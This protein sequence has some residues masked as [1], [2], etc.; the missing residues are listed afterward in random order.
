MFKLCYVTHS[1][2]SHMPEMTAVAKPPGCL[3]SAAVPFLACPQ[4]V[5]WQIPQYALVGE[6][7]ACCICPCTCSSCM[8]FRS[9]LCLHCKCVRQ[10]HRA[11]RIQWLSSA[12]HAAGCSEVFSLVGAYEL[13]YS[14]ASRLSKIRIRSHRSQSEPISKPPAWKP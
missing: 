14:Q 4:S 6:Y 10:P 8:Q 7:I 2:L 12:C 1:R 5:W 13:F 11:L 9:S 3:I